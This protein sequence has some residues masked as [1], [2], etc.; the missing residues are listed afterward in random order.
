MTDAGRWKWLASL[1]CNQFYLERDG[2]HACN[3][4]TAAQW[5][6]MDHNDDFARVPA[7][8]V[9]RMKATNTIWKLQIY[10][11]TPVGFDVWYGASAE[12][13]IDAAMRDYAENG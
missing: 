4:M 13:V 5:I 6:E 12:A 10:P 1:K 2:D 11:N 9:E 7:D 8:E 3:Y